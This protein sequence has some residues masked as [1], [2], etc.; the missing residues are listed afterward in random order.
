M[1]LGR[2]VCGLGAILLLPHL[3]VAQSPKGNAIPPGHWAATAVASLQARN[4]LPPTKSGAGF[5]GN[6]PVTRYE[7]AVVLW[8]LV[9][10]MEAAAKQPRGKSS[11][12]RELDGPQAMRRLV[13]DG[14]LGA[15]SAILKDPKQSVGE[16]ELAKALVEVIAR[17][18]E[19][20]VPVTPDSKKS[21]PMDRHPGGGS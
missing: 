7:L 19:K 17:I 15:E 3:A 16:G 4:I 12:Q 1:T 6:K 11:V 2:T 8:K 10:H 13:A 9:Q 18:Q 14:Y 20:T 21:I 5:D